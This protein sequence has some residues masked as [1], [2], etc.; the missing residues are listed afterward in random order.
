MSSPSGPSPQ[1]Q[2]SFWRVSASTK[3]RCLLVVVISKLLSVR[4]VFGATYLIADSG[5]VERPSGAA[6]V[7]QAC[8][9][10]SVVSQLVHFSLE[11][12]V[13]DGT[14]IAYTSQAMP[15]GA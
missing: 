6:G 15:S 3:L 7:R 10:S 5:A 13:P 8:K 2:P 4:G 14:G 12:S 9:M 1:E 11:S